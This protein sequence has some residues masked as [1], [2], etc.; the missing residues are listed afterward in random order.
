M[1]KIFMCFI[2][3]FLSFS[4]MANT[5]LSSTI[6]FKATAT[7]NSFNLSN[8]EN[9]KKTTALI[10]KE[11]VE[12]K[13]ESFLVLETGLKIQKNEAVLKELQEKGN[14]V[15]PITLVNDTIVKTGSYPT[16]EEIQE[17]CQLNYQT[18]FK[19]FGKIEVNGD[20]ASPL[21]KFLKKEK[22]GI[23]GS[24]IKWNFTKFLVDREGNVLKRF[25]SATTPEQL[26]KEL[27]AV[28]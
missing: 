23:A 4:S 1:E 25:A 7:K 9:Y 10:I 22:G 15:L 13:K 14:D 6:N 3:L 17:F 5:N 28:L 27:V 12:M 18:T 26:E 24:A 11:K 16:N 2:G 8:T 19:T 21:Y 20:G